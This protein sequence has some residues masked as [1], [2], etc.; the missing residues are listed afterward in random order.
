METGPGFEGRVEVISPTVGKRFQVEERESP[1][2]RGHT[3]QI[4][5][6]TRMGGLEKKE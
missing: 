3:S 1:P 2:R 6:I 5:L 4:Q